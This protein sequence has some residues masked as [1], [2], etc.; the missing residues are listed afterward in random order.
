MKYISDPLGSP[1][2]KSLITTCTVILNSYSN[3]TRFANVNARSLKN[4]TAEVVDHVLNNNIDVCIVTET[5]LKAVDTVS[6]AALSPPGYSF[7]NFPRQS[8]RMGG[9]AGIMFN[10]NFKAILKEGGE[11]RS[12]EYSEWNLQAPN[13]TIKI[14]AVYRPHSRTH[15]VPSTVFFE[16]FSN[17]LE[18]IVLCVEVLLIT[19]DFNFHLDDPYDTN[20]KAFSA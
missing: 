1:G 19:G 15:P 18:T 9:G 4:K 20:T 7:A 11:K 8:N 10:T 17:L 2:L 12:F 5:W 14:L 16:E 6:I 13:C 3:F